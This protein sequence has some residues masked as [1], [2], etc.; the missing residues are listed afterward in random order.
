MLGTIIC[1]YFAVILKYC[2]YILK[3][4]LFQFYIIHFTE[5]ETGND[6]VV[7][8]YPS[9]DGENFSPPPAIN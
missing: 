7:S 8:L 1:F 3:S 4:S 9:F 6:F 5:K 2:V